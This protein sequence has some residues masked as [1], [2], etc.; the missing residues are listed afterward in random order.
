MELQ[1]KLNYIQQNIKVGKS[2]T[3]KFANYT[4]RNC[5]DI[6]HAVKPLL[7]GCNLKLSDQIK[8]LGEHIYVEA[9]AELIL[10]EETIKTT[11]SAFVDLHRKGMSAEQR[12]GSA[13]SYARKYCLS[14]LFLL[15][16]AQDP[17]ELKSS[18]EAVTEVS[19]KI[20]IDNILEDL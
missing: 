7:D 15:D 20:D 17:D 12:V 13:S 10:G 3:N 16:D 9:T 5:E 6:L 2:R 18:P 4:Y 8:I 19:D 11:A 1:K 14:G